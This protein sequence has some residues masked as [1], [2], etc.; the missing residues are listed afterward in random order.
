MSGGESTLGDESQRR[1]RHPLVSLVAAFFSVFVWTLAWA[2]TLVAF[3]TIKI[4]IFIYAVLS[5]SL[6]LTINFYTLLAIG[7]AAAIALSYYIRYRYLNDYAE[8]KEP[9]LDK[10]SATSLHPDIAAAADDLSAPRFSNYLDEFLQAIRVFGFLEK[11][12]FHELARHL[13]TR[14][15]IAGDTLA[16]D[17]DLSFYCVVDGHVQVFAE[18]GRNADAWDEDSG[19]YQLLNEVGP[20]GTLSSLFTILS[21]FTE[22]VRISWQDNPREQGP[23]ENEDKDVSHL[24]TGWNTLHWQDNPR[25][26]G[27]G[28][29]EDK[30][31]SHLDLANESGT[32]RP[33]LRR[34]SL[35]SSGSTALGRASDP[36]F[37][38][39]P[40]RTTSIGGFAT[41]GSERSGTSRQGAS[42]PPPGS[43]IQDEYGYT[44]GAQSEHK[45]ARNSMR[46]GTIA[47][48]TVDTTLA[49]IPAEA[50]RRLTHKFPKASAH[51]VQGKFWT[52]C[53]AESLLI[54]ST[55]I[56]TRFS[57]VTFNAMHK[58]LGLTVELLRTE[59]DINELACHPLP[60]EFY[61]GGGMQRLRQRFASIPH[62]EDD[63]QAVQTEDDTITDTDDY[64]GKRT[65]HRGSSIGSGTISAGSLNAETP[66][67]DQPSVGRKRARFPAKT[68]SVH[69]VTP[70]TSRPSTSQSQNQPSY[71]GDLHTMAGQMNDSENYRPG[72]ASR[73]VS[74]AKN[75]TGE[76]RRRSISTHA[77]GAHATQAA[78]TQDF[79]LRDEVMSSIA[80]SIGLLQPPLSDS[81]GAS[82]LLS[83]RPTTSRSPF[84]SSA[85][86]TPS[87][88]KN[89]LRN[90]AMFGSAFSNLSHLQSQDDASSVT[91][92]AGMTP[93]SLSGLD[94]DVEILFFSA[95]STLVRAGERNAGLFYVI[96]GFLDVSIPQD[97]PAYGKPA[98]P[99]GGVA[100]VSKPP[101]RKNT[102][103]PELSVRSSGQDKSGA[104]NAS[105][106][107][108]TS[109]MAQS[110]PSKHLFTRMLAW[111]KL[112]RAWLSLSPRSTYSQSKQVA[113]RDTLVTSLTGTP[114]Y[115]DIRAKTD[116]YVGFLPSHALERLLERRPIVLLTLAKRLISLLSPLVL[117]IDASLDWQQVDAGQVLW[118]PEDT[119]DSFYMVLNGRLRAITEKD[120][121]V[122]IVGEYGQ[123]DTVGELDVITSS[124]RRTTL[125]AI[126]D[127]ELARMPMSLFNAIS[128]RHPQTT[129]QLLRMIASR[130][131][132]EV[133]HAS[134]YPRQQKANELGRNNPNLK[135]V[136]ILPSSRDVPVVVFATKLQAALEDMGAPT[137][138]LTQA[139][140]TRHLGR[141]AFTKLGK[142]K[143]AGWLAE[144]EQRYRIVLYVADTPVGSPWTQTC[145]RQADS[146]M[147]IGMGDDPTLGEYERLLMGTK[148]TARRELVLL[149]PNKNVA[150]GSTREW[151]KNRPWIHGHT[152]VELPGLIQPEVQG[153][154]DKDAA[155]IIAFNKIKNKVQLEIQ[156]YTRSQANTRPHRP[157]HFSDFAR[158]AR[159]LCGKSVGLVLGGGG[160][161]G[162][163]HLGV[164][165]A[166]EDRGI[167]IDHVGGTS[168]GAFIGGLYAREGDVLSSALR[169]KQ[170]SGRM[171][172]FW[173]L[174]SDVTWPVVA[175]TTGHFFNRGIYKA[176]SNLHIE[177]MWLP[178][179]C[180]TTNII[181]SRMDVHDTGYAWRYI[182]Y[183]R[184]SMTLVGLLPP[185]CDNG[186]MLVDGGYVDNLPVSTMISHGA[187]IVFAV[188]VG[189][190]Y[191][192]SPRNYGDTV[193]GWWVAL[194][195]W[196]PFSSTR[197]IPDIT[198]IQGRLTYVSS[199]PTLEE[200]KITPGCFYMQMPVHEY[201]TLQ[202]GRYDEIYQ[203]GY[204]A[205]V[206]ML[207]QWDAEDRLPSRSKYR[208]LGSTS[209]HA[210]GASSAV[211]VRLIKRGLTE[212]VLIS[213][214]FSLAYAGGMSGA[215]CT[216]TSPWLLRTPNGLR[217]SKGSRSVLHASS[218][219]ATIDEGNARR[220]FDQ[221]RS[222]TPLTPTTP[223]VHPFADVSSDS[224]SEVDTPH[225]IIVCDDEGVPVSPLSSR[226]R[227]TSATD[228][229][230]VQIVRARTQRINTARAHSHSIEEIRQLLSPP[231]DSHVPPWLKRET[232]P[233]NTPNEPGPSSTSGTLNPRLNGPPPPPPRSSA[234]RRPRVITKDGDERLN[235]P[236]RTSRSVSMPIT[237]QY[238]VSL[239]PPPRPRNRVHRL[240]TQLIQT[241]E[242]PTLPDN[243]EPKDSRPPTLTIPPR[244]D[245]LE[246]RLSLY[247]IPLTPVGIPLPLSTATSNFPQSPHSTVFY[248]VG[249]PPIT[250]FH[251][252]FLPS[253]KATSVRSSVIQDDLSPRP[254]EDRPERSANRLSTLSNPFG[255]F[256]F[257]RPFTNN[258]ASG[259]SFASNVSGSSARSPTEAESIPIGLHRATSQDADREDLLL[260]V[261]PRSSWLRTGFEVD[262]HLPQA[263]ED[264]EDESTTEESSR[265]S[266]E[267]SSIVSVRER[268]KSLP[269]IPVASLNKV[270]RVLGKGASRAL[271]SGAHHH[272][273]DLFSPPSMT[274][275]PENTP[276]AVVQLDPTQQS[277]LPSTAPPSAFSMGSI[278]R[279]LSKR[280]SPTS[281][282][283]RS[284]DVQRLSSP[285]LM[286]RMDRFIGRTPSP[287]GRT[288]ELDSE[289]EAPSPPPIPAFP[290]SAHGRQHSGS[291]LLASAALTGRPSTSNMRTAS[292]RAEMV[293]KTRKIQQVLGDVPPLSGSAFYRVSRAARSEESLVSPTT[294]VVVIGSSENRGH[295]STASLSSRPLL[296]LSPALQTDG[297]LNIRTSGS[298]DDFGLGLNDGGLSPV[299][300]SQPED[301]EGEGE[302]EDEAMVA[303]R[304]K[305]AKVAKLHRYLGSRVPAHLVLGLD[306][307]W[308]PE[309]DLPDV[310]S[311]DGGESASVFSRKKRRASDGDYT[312]L[313]ADMNDLSVMSSEEKAR[314][315]RRKAKMEKVGLSFYAHTFSD[316]R[317]MFGERPPQKLY[318]VHQPGVDTPADH[319]SD[320]EEVPLS[321]SEGGEH[322][323][324]YRASFN[325]LAYF[326]SNADRDSLE[327][328]YDIVSGPS[329]DSEAQRNQFAARRKRAAKLSNFF[330]VSYRDLFGAVLDILESDVKE[331]KE[332]GSLSAAE[333]Q[334]L[335][336]KLKSLKD[337][338]EKIRG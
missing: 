156:K 267:K 121:D 210:I 139:S 322:Y 5:Y 215:T 243:S 273:P 30:D 141:H 97:E 24:G 83:P 129:V 252:S 54:P 187:S 301:V 53:G 134:I 90:T 209:R 336:R 46:Q 152:H 104:S 8:L 36:R 283:R 49:V 184:A 22:D 55:V 200:A 288:R 81:V 69:T 96:D 70:S 131:R 135:T 237:R 109:R 254:S 117:N 203:V 130:V 137:S 190:L 274:S 307:T 276:T 319:E 332:E 287:A 40:T 148:T 178:F 78:T 2:K 105:L 300:M 92:L 199:I 247:S 272:V 338:G 240:P 194:N 286:A 145:I 304:A 220:G 269:Y 106:D 165:R 171:A 289:D 263:D 56:L 296:A 35:S 217:A 182:R 183:I 230:T 65:H 149:H 59:K 88:S 310:R 226:T 192:N 270:D 133:D 245:S 218:G 317:Q 333:T 144:Q 298:G 201:G 195:R 34:S 208:T 122:N 114:S 294:A 167:P 31:V 323:Q 329:D 125:H 249:S 290:R 302:E 297:L 308:D 291:D 60:N 158:L 235:S 246:R 312:L 14:R 76:S 120:D 177:D 71:A 115:V 163:A 293:K 62:T 258:R 124:S 282:R 39:S 180:N 3:V 116:T 166:L 213:S 33:V 174:L 75:W 188:D 255:D 216:T 278:G 176:F 279:R 321:G 73:A 280:S 225:V 202:F 110:K 85:S 42:S 285:G 244:R 198:D 138:F 266:T 164:I 1:D 12:V 181:T 242:T 6:T 227:Y 261:T 320:P 91:S 193:S 47:R 271:I 275:S 224:D 315:V 119:S 41:P 89:A 64:F 102:I 205:A 80:K 231:P 316:P 95:G 111:T 157:K 52:P 277:F 331:D 10:P 179:F 7:L 221:Q 154:Q 84:P 268:A 170:F 13:Q 150:P 281:E 146:I 196:N 318:Q 264:E 127:T 259:I 17:Q 337:K 256:S 68:Q 112:R 67:P 173:K 45:Y 136:C 38:M 253:C 303:R 236:V 77:D 147:V 103:R 28:E 26:Q 251:T 57:R 214:S 160:A 25:E 108:T 142:L 325:S 191:D 207:D 233:G 284:E 128:I 86:I 94:N 113:L 260:P 93:M 98:N 20:G 238:F 327:G 306:E 234:R 309:R 143:A 186:D 87:S 21:L 63:D 151:L 257:S 16:L 175:Y 241:S 189:S 32:T 295:R 335:L 15:L 229:S 29:N 72:P 328:L 197:N 326:V 126:R 169:A 4:P 107:Q 18:T 314:A 19:G 123:G 132:N 265:K 99:P 140:V 58:Y 206:D 250:P 79:D 248:S 212:A 9:P 61:S 159:R 239:P 330:G 66:L 51:I 155:A 48:A 334:D 118:R 313:E 292:E 161:R 311:E 23:G 50:F 37:A 43:E 223:P 211:G 11:P 204:S 162:I 185:L 262:V 172:S 153:I 222:P 82:P 305:R 232:K 219:L 228:D 27:P 168:I 101:K 324:S 299:A 74:Y 100:T 44:T